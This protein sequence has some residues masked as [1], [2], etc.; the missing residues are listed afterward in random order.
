MLPFLKSPPS[1]GRTESTSFRLIVHNRYSKVKNL[2]RATLGRLDQQMKTLL[3]D[4]ASDIDETQGHESLPMAKR[5][6]FEPCGSKS[7]CYMTGVL[8]RPRLQLTSSNVPLKSVGDAGLF[9]RSFGRL[10]TC[11]KLHQAKLRWKRL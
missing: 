9:P 3:T 4:Q 7:P 8:R 10:A 11:T 2:N 1:H 6:G 5:S